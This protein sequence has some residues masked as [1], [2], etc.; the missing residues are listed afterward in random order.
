MKWKHFAFLYWKKNHQQPLQ[1]SLLCGLFKQGQQR[2]CKHFSS[3]CLIS[4]LHSRGLTQSEGLPPWMLAKSILTECPSP[5]RASTGASLGSR[6][7]F[8][9]S[10]AQLHGSTADGG[11]KPLRAAHWFWLSCSHCAAVN[12]LR[13]GLPWH[14]D[15]VLGVLPYVLN[16]KPRQQTKPSPCHTLHPCVALRQ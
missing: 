7:K 11:I 2:H 6:I 16:I 1:A 13:C 3:K 10:W 4:W 12:M 9:T 14:S 5:H 8:S 15:Q